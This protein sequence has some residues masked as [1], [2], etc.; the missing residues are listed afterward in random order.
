MDGNVGIVADLKVV[1][2]TDSVDNSRK[3]RRSVS[4]SCIPESLFQLIDVITLK[5]I[6]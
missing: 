4:P 6:Q 5:P 2:F 1:D 3:T